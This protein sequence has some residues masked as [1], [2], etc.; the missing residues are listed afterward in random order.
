MVFIPIAQ[1]KLGG[2]KSTES[3]GNGLL[4][5]LE[6]L[7]PAMVFPMHLQC[8]DLALYKEVAKKVKESFPTMFTKVAESSNFVFTFGQQR[9]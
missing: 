8:E 2:C 3:I 6:I 7:N 9:K 5:T 4:L 1:G